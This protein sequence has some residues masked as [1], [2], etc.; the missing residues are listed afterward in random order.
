MLVDQ[1]RFMADVHASEVAYRD[2]NSGTEITFVE[3]DTRSNQI[4][5]WLIPG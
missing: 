3:W 5:R 1:L 4:A 2:L